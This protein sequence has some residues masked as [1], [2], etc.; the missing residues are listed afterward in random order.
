MLDKNFYMQR[1]DRRNYYIKDHLGS[2]R[3]V[4][5]Q[6]GEIV[7]AQDYYPFGE[8]LRTYTTGSGQNDKYKFTEKER[9]IETGYDYFG[10]RFYDSRIGRWLSVDPLAEMYPGWSPYNYTMNNP[11]RYIDPNG[12]YSAETADGSDPE[13]DDPIGKDEDGKPSNSWGKGVHSELRKRA[14]NIYV[15]KTKLFYYSQLSYALNEGQG[16]NGTFFVAGYYSVD[17]NFFTNQ[18]KLKIHAHAFTSVQYAYGKFNFLGSASLLVNDAVV[19][20]KSLV[21]EG[22]WTIKNNFL[23]VGNAQFSL[24]KAGKIALKLWVSYVG[25]DFAGN[26]QPEYDLNRIIKIYGY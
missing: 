18:W 23:E 24:P 4:V 11:L 10:A 14:E 12:M 15:T 2:I 6:G 19:E 13:E 16:L 3:V 25:H 26:V 1:R 9:D 5:D 17:K 22:S 21:P 7:S 8:T 20:K